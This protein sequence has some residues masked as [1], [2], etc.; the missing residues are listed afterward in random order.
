[1]NFKLSIVSLS[2]S[3]VAC[4]GGGGVEEKNSN[5]NDNN[6]KKHQIHIGKQEATTYTNM[7]VPL[8]TENL[9]KVN[10]V[11]TS[12][13]N[14]SNTT[15]NSNNYIIS[16]GNKA[17]F[18]A[19]EPGTYRVNLSL[20][21]EQDKS[22]NKIFEPAIITV[23][24]SIEQVQCL[25]HKPANLSIGLNSLEMGL[26]NKEDYT[27][28]TLTTIFNNDIVTYD[29]EIR[30]RGNSTWM[31]EKR[32]YR[33][34]LAKRGN[35]SNS[36][37]G[38]PESRNWALLAN[39]YDGT[40]LRNAIALC[41]GQ[42]LLT[43]SWTPKYQFTNVDYNGEYQG[44][45]MLA[46]HIEIAP[47][48][49]NIPKS[50]F[51]GNSFLV[52]LTPKNRIVAKNTYVESSKGMK[53]NYEVKNDVSLNNLEYQT[54][55]EKIVSVLDNHS[56]TLFNEGLIYKP[57][58]EDFVN[59]QSFI[60]YWIAN[61]IFNTADVF[62]ASTNVFKDINGKI[63]YGPMWDYD[64]G[65]GNYSCRNVDKIELSLFNRVGLLTD[66]S[67]SNPQ[68]IINNPAFKELYDKRWNTAYDQFP[69]LMKYADNQ[70]NEIEDSLNKN[71]TKWPLNTKGII[72]DENCSDLF[73]G[74]TAR[75]Q[76]TH[77][78]HY[79]MKRVLWI[80]Q[81]NNPSRYINLYN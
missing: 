10:Y 19:T 53:F 74:N 27:N 41:L 69:S 51:T 49:V 38:M 11:W 23:K 45:Y 9:D 66:A 75:E 42:N 48:K 47:H 35:A 63:T 22:L 24:E 36:I 80:D 16:E 8:A 60:D 4:G 12:S 40:S 18:Y 28:T 58:Y 43:E 72:M 30:G 56:D 55:L 81:K 34:R 3:L 1:M 61:D 21:S 15:P 14:V 17:Y 76:Y 71:I 68:S 13:E 79:L 62:F 50:D 77:M 73:L 78:K 46:E 25:A 67:Y 32:P 20:S 7:L 44:L 52:E 57:N 29:T 6:P 54:Q 37:L 2:I 70:F 65:A 39:Y 33:I 59:T 31:A 26:I 64:L 5:Q